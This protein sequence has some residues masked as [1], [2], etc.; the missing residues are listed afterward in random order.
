MELVKTPGKRTTPQG[1]L[2]TFRISTQSKLT[3]QG[4]QGD[5]NVAATKNCHFYPSIRP[6]QCGSGTSTYLEVSALHRRQE[7]V[8]TTKNSKFF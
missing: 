3:R 2:V 6:V 7:I 1:G 4:L 8:F 5:D